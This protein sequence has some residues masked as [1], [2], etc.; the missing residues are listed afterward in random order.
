MPSKGISADG[1]YALVEKE[2]HQQRS[3]PLR[4]N[5]GN[6]PLKQL[7]S[8]AIDAAAAGSNSRFRCAAGHINQPFEIEQGVRPT[9]SARL[10][11]P[12]VNVYFRQSH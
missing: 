8:G 9:F 10:T 4:F 11:L 1:F 3:N 7:N 6:A 12:L 5:S 2:Q